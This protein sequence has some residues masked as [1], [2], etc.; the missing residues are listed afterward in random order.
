MFV[1]RV[2]FMSYDLK[3]I[4]TM[5]YYVNARETQ[6]GNQQCQR[7]YMQHCVHKT[8]DEEKQNSKIQHNTDN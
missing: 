4:W 3:I 2:K 7:H 1:L 6:M 5:L 8:Q